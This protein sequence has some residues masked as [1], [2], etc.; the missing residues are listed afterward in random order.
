MSVLTLCLAAC[1]KE[2]AQTA[3]PVE[4]VP[5]VYHSTIEYGDP[6][7]I[8]DNAGPL[9]AYIRFPVAGEA[10]DAAIANWAN[11][12]YFNS[13]REI[14]ELHKQD[15]DALG[16]VNIQFDSYL[17]KDRY[18]GII[19]SGMFM[20]SHM[21][22]PR[23]IIKTFNIDVA[24]GYLL[25]N[26]DILD[27]SK[28]DGI[29]GLLREKIDSDLADAAGDLDGMDERWLE[30]IMIGHDGIVVCL[31][32]GRF[33]PVYLGALKY[34]LPYG[35]LGDAVL[36]DFGAT[37][38]HS[39]NDSIETAA[40]PTDS[41]VAT[42][43]E[44][45]AATPTDIPEATPTDIPEPTAEPTV[46]PDPTI[47]PEP[48]A[49]TPF[50]PAAPPQGAN[51]DASKPIIAL[52]FDDGP[53]KFT[54]QILDLIEKYDIRV[55]FCVVGN[56]V[57]ARSETVKR[58]FDL[59]CEV[60][61][62]SWD[63][64]DLSKLSADEIRKQLSDTSQTI[65]S[66]TGHYPKLFRPP[67]GATSSTLKEVSAEM[68]YAIINWSVDPLDWQSRNA[69]MVYA[70]I[71]NDVHDRAIVLSHD[72]YGSTADAMERVIPELLSKGYQIVTVSELMYY[73]GKTLEA[74]VLYYS[75]K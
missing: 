18:A 11:D 42:P 52:S 55:T 17:V 13:R 61:G 22:H 62:H 54:S 75:G 56:L 31:E 64:R 49:V 44:T 25:E 57:N 19:N 65:E 20:S 24:N 71:M 28:L 70:A 9:F 16:E 32:R 59:G 33:L 35:E 14:N 66:V 46:E 74:G 23:D 21:A 12:L 60:I 53:S 1:A 39:N 36:L 43:T 5:P 29:L 6:D 40:E 8:T 3:P 37:P 4:I 58:A 10:T 45:P 67:Y 68:G 2:T 51:I 48:P 41:P 7:L 27:Y 15:P 47:E 26:F 72:L 63:H 73:S 69:D 38:E 30:H 34:T 50:V